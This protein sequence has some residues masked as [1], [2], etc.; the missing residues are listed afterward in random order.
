MDIDG[1]LVHR[2]YK[3][4]QAKGL[5]PQGNEFDPACVKR[6]T[7]ALVLSHSRMVVHSTWV[8]ANKPEEICESFIKAGFPKELFYFDFIARNDS[9][10]R[11][12]E[13]AIAEWL[14]RHPEIKHHLIIDDE[15][16]EGRDQVLIRS[17][18]FNHGLEDSHEEQIIN[19]FA[20][21]IGRT[22]T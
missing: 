8:Y 19:Y 21:K 1:V 13:P 3:P 15:I 6:L 5:L 20:G 12:K 11:A 22:R 2:N 16:V 17:G 18:W 4:S 10:D 9:E 14:N 7:R